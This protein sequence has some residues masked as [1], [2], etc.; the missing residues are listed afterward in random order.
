[1]EREGKKE[2]KHSRSRS[3][4]KDDKKHHDRDLRRSARSPSS[5]PSSPP[6]KATKRSASRTKS[7]PVRTKSRSDGDDKEAKDKEAKERERDRSRRRERPKS[8]EREKRH[9][10]KSKKRSKRDAEEEK[11]ERR[12][13]KDKDKE[14]KI[15]DKVYD[16]AERIERV[17]RGERVTDR[18]E[19]RDRIR[20]S[21]RD[22][23]RATERVDRGERTRGGAAGGD[24]DRGGYRGR[25]SDFA[26]ERYN[27]DRERERRYYV[28]REHKE[29][30]NSEQYRGYNDGR[31]KGG[32]RDRRRRSRSLSL[33]PPEVAAT[34]E[35]NAWR[36]KGTTRHDWRKEQQK[37]ERNKDKD[38]KD[39][40]GDEDDEE[41][42][43]EAARLR[44]EAIKAK[45]A[46]AETKSPEHEA[47]ATPEKHL[48]SESESGTETS[49]GSELQHRL[50]TDASG[51]K[52]LNRYIREQKEQHDEEKA[53]R[54]QKEDTRDGEEKSKS[55]SG[56]KEE[57]TAEQIEK[58]EENMFG[59]FDTHQ[60]TRVEG[61]G[62]TGA[63]AHD[64]DDQ[65]G[66]YKPQLNEVM[67]DRYQ[68]FADCCGKGVFSNV[69]KAKDKKHKG[70]DVAIK[71]IR[72]N[73]MM[74]KAAEKEVAIL[75]MLN[76]HDKGDKR[77]VVR[78]LR[79]FDYRDHL[80]MVFECMWDN[81]RT[82]IKKLGRPG[83]GVSLNLVHAW[84]RQLFIA[85]RLLQKCNIIHAD[86]KPDNL[87]VGGSGKTPILK[88]CDIGSAFDASENEIT[89]Y[90]VSRFYRAPEIILGLRYTTSI[91]VWAAAVTIYELYT[92]KILFKGATNNEML[93][94]V[95]EIRGKMLTKVLRNATFGKNHYN[96]N[97]DFVFEDKD[98]ATGKP[99]SRVISDFPNA[100]PTV[101]TD[102]LLEYIP[103]G[104]LRS[105]DLY[106]ETYVKLVKTMG[107]FLTRC[108]AL[109]FEKRMTP[110]E[111]L[112][113]VFPKSPFPDATKLRGKKNR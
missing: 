34:D 25:G 59:E 47:G 100:K 62:V 15:V 8:T 20:A 11:G 4:R 33:A 48:D 94:K 87:L 49:L 12:R 18:G 63:S 86:L 5:A 80:C 52:D 104:R 46:A 112:Q 98:P 110:D 109:D 57:K 30:R 51:I 83:R 111:A 13:D 32:E 78:L 17:D 38:D 27:H 14:E 28:H 105:E 19:Q 66:Y 40:S 39:E 79:T 61:M 55:S 71:V 54:K 96:E 6:A 45:Y 43:L 53:K 10:K 1:M 89:P 74:R 102:M 101:I 69:V 23:E 65:D 85:L 70:V 90:V 26:Q 113:H 88:I 76:S 36:R 9:S 44:R 7:S 16:G 99:I 108:L 24:R 22:R 77:F 82:A 93:K 35:P 29:K 37:N 3:P 72:N 68:V 92:S 107:E 60:R 2:R 91:D 106:D 67:D 58:E 103:K 75:R 97:N 41:K 50:Q 81:A 42:I 84:T 56:E 73:D 95:S 21:E 31:R 64:W